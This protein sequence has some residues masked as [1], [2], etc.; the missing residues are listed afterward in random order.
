M[1]VIFKIW[2]YNYITAP[3]SWS[4][5]ADISSFSFGSDAYLLQGKVNKNS[6]A[7]KFRITALKNNSKLADVQFMSL[8]R[9]KECQ[10]IEEIVKYN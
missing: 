3:F 5:W 8:E 2:L 7:K 10:L 1:K 6:N 4:R 9:L